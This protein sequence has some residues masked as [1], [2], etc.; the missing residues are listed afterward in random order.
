MLIG[1]IFM[2][3]FAVLM[4]VGICAGVIISESLLA[5]IILFILWTMMVVAIVCMW[6]LL[7]D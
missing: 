3:I 2:T 7:K 1:T 4:G 6:W 5:S